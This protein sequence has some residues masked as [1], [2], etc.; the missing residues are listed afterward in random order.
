[1]IRCISNLDNKPTSATLITK[2]NTY[3]I[4]FQ[5][6]PLYILFTYQLCHVQTLININWLKGVKVLEIFREKMLDNASIEKN[7]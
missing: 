2:R 7:N 4:Q 6:R 5:N 3:K 1:M